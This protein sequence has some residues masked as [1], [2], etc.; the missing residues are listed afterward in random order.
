M[1]GMITVEEAEEVVALPP[2]QPSLP[3]GEWI[4]KNLFSSIGNGVL[5]VLFALLL[6]F[7]FRGL[8]NFAFENPERD[9]DAVR[10]NLRLYMTFA[11]PLDQ[12]VRVWVSLGIV[13][14]LSGLSAGLWSPDGYVSARRISTWFLGG[15]AVLLAAALAVQGQLQRDEN[16]EFLIDE[17]LELIR[18]SWASG[19]GSRISWFALA[20]ILIG[21]G[22]AIWFGLGDRRRNTFVR[23]VNL[24]YAGFGVIVG[25][26]WVVRYGHYNGSPAEGTHYADPDSL[27][28]MSTRLPWT[29]MWVLV[30]VS[31]FVGKAVRGWPLLKPLAL[32]FWGLLPFI[33][34]WVVLRDPDIDWAHVWT[35]D[36]PMYLAFAVIGGAVLFTLTNPSLGEIGRALAFVLLLVA[37]FTFVGGFFGWFSMLQKARLSFVFLAAFALVANNF[38]GEFAKRRTFVIGWLLTLG[39]M[40]Y[41]VTL[42]NSASTLNIRSDSFLGGFMFTIF[43]AVFGL[44]FSFPLGVLLALA[45]TSSL[46]I[47]RLLATTFIEVVR[48]IP[49]ITVLFFFSIMLPLFLPEGMEVAE[50]G[51]VIVG[52]V[53]FSSAYLAENVR[54][55]LQ[56]VRRGQYEA[57]DAT[58]LTTAQRTGL[59]VLPQALRV[60]IPPLVGQTISSYKETSLFAIVGIF[61]FLRIANNV[62]PNQS[63]PI[64][65]VGHKREGLLFVSL[66]Y[67]IGSYA[68]SKYSQKL[69]KK[70]GVGSR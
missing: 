69:E 37:V 57:A 32:T 68:M 10:A 34:F 47:F 65:F 25:S 14:S 13:L 62:V 8:V 38:A 23:T 56:S 24:T 27:V 59:I 41:F 36:L 44:M 53:L 40:H 35:T 2:E 43:A 7:A 20:A 58:G 21:A 18:G 67:W 49:F 28:A 29:V 22:A 4:R 39:V 63:S 64:N 45:R 70:L 61:D 5:T 9:W 48:G 55:G 31:Y 30:G 42:I 15:G 33:V 3:P 11:Y 52:L 54:G 6:V 1:S 12:Y 60:S 17:D 26:L 46:P 16:G 66:I 50:H 19:L 51:A